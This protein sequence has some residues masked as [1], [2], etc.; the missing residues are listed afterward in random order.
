MLYSTHDPRNEVNDAMR[1]N[2]CEHGEIRHP[3]GWQEPPSSSGES[4]RKVKFMI[5]SI[6]PDKFV[7]AMAEC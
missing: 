2:E 7:L 6:H 5:N 3:D 4:D 1:R